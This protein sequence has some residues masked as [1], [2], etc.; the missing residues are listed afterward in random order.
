MQHDTPKRPDI[1]TKNTYNKL[2]TEGKS[3]TKKM[4]D[5]VPNIAKLDW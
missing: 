4:H 3:M 2:E 1:V 5:E